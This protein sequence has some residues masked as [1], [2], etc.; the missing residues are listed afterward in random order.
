[1]NFLLFLK[2]ITSIATIQLILRT[3]VYSII[4]ALCTLEMIK[5]YDASGMRPC[6]TAADYTID[7]SISG[8][9][10]NP[11]SDFL[12]TSFADVAI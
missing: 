4:A 3:Q 6:G 5:W 12:V 1:M 10:S 7:N 2:Y 9:Y 8:T 11:Y